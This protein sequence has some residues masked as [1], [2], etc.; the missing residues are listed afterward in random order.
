MTD[1]YTKPELGAE[2]ELCR[3][4]REAVT[5]AGGCSYCKHRARLFETVGRRAACG[6]E[7]PRA[8]PRCV[9]QP[10]GFAFDEGAYSGGRMPAGMQS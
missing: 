5:G 10:D 1:D 8:F 4:I 7:P 2:R 9:D 6:L 3:A